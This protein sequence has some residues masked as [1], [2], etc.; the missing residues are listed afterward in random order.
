MRRLHAVVTTT[1]AVIAV[2]GLAVGPAR[3]A[4]PGHD[5][6]VTAPEPA[7]ICGIQTSLVSVINHVFRDTQV[8]GT[9]TSTSTGTVKTTF[10]AANGRSVTISSAGRLEVTDVDNGAGTRT[11]TVTNTG[12]PEKVTSGTGKPLL[13]DRGPVSQVYLVVLNDPGTD[14]DVFTLVGS[15]TSTGRTPTWTASS[16]C[17]ATS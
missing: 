8:D 5:H 4:A 16:L 17:S 6:L 15:R 11:A 7:E 9:V 3:A 12:Q 13:A 14:D 1:A 10:T 2:L